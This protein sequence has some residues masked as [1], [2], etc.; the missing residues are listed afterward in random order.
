[1]PFPHRAGHQSAFYDPHKQRRGYIWNPVCRISYT[2]VFHY[3]VARRF[4]A[5]NA[6]LIWFTIIA[7]PKSGM[8]PF[9]FRCQSFVIK[10]CSVALDF[11]IGFLEILRYTGCKNQI[12]FQVGQDF[13]GFGAVQIVEFVIGH[14]RW[15]RECLPPE[16]FLECL[17]EYL[18]VTVIFEDAIERLI[19][20][21]IYSTQRLHPV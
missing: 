13:H 9:I 16:M 7:R 2:A 20:H 3:R 11:H 21:F 14:A 5:G 6:D 8:Q 4:A 17:G 12:G 19:G 1:M 10:N 15:G 18:L